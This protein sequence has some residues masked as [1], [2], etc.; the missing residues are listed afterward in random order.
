[1]AGRAELSL[2][3]CKPYCFRVASSLALLISSPL[4]LV[5]V[6]VRFPRV[7]FTSSCQPVCVFLVPVLVMPEIRQDIVAAL[8]ECRDRWE[9]EVRKGSVESLLAFLAH[10]AR[11]V[12]TSDELAASGLGRAITE[13]SL[14]SFSSD[15]VR[16]QVSRLRLCW[17]TRYE[18]R[19][20]QRALCAELA[21][22]GLGRS[23]DRPA[24]SLALLCQ[25]I[26]K[27]SWLDEVRVSSFKKESAEVVAQI[28][29]LIDH[30]TSRGRAPLLDGGIAKRIRGAAD[31][32][33]VLSEQD[34]DSV[35]RDLMQPLEPPS[36]GPRACIQAAGSM[37]Q[38]SGSRSAM[39]E[40]MRVQAL[41]DSAKKS[42]P[43][44]AVHVLLSRSCVLCCFRC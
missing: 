18:Q 26:R 39:V 1:M 14:G 29:R 13:E 12:G 2:L 11:I 40:R 4:L 10:V 30:E 21:E 3:C 37:I 22:H 32:V 16:Q 8:A 17:K 27:V 44:C 7:L 38:G 5:L 6:H 9:V 24:V 41:L 15:A 34:E 43:R 31:V 25:G 42:H 28:G 36:G 20:A 23:L 33:A 35:H 19:H